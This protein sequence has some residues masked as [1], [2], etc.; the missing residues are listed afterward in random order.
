MEREIVPNEKWEIHRRRVVS[1][2]SLGSRKSLNT[3]TQKKKNS[4]RE[5]HCYHRA[6]IDNNTSIKILNEMWFLKQNLVS[7]KQL[8]DR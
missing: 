5:T 8:L 1:S 2:L 3:H 4:F 7:W 6:F